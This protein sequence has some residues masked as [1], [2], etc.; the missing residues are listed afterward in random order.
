MHSVT[1]SLLVANRKSLYV[2]IIVRRRKIDKTSKNSEKSY[3][4]ASVDEYW[5][6]NT[7]IL[8][9]NQRFL[10]AYNTMFICIECASW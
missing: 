9:K 6:S 7:W 4:Q 1:E 5:S 2:T 10:V 3:N 8:W